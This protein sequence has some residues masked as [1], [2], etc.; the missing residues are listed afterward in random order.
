[1]TSC[2]FL[3]D[4]PCARMYENDSGAL[5]TAVPWNRFSS[6]PS[7]SSATP[8]HAE[9]R[10]VKQA[11]RTVN[12]ELVDAHGPSVP[13]F[14][15]SMIWEKLLG[16]CREYAC[17]RTCQWSALMTTIRELLAHAHAPP[18]THHRTRTRTVSR[19][20]TKDGGNLARISGVKRS[21]RDLTTTVMVEGSLSEADV[22]SRLGV[23]IT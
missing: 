22:L 13:G 17:S 3:G 1:M 19:V 7:F 14:N 16:M 8:A 20:L 11:N 18:H 6:T 10:S 12:L 2:I 23:H 15:R 5:V 4:M 21:G 9:E